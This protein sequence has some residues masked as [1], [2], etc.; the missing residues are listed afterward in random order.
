M[1]VQM[2]DS[3][4]MA[5]LEGTVI[6]YYTSGSGTPAEPEPLADGLDLAAPFPNPAATRATVRYTTDAAGPVRVRLLDVLGRQLAVLAD[7]D[8]PPGTHRAELDAGR[9]AAG[10]YAV[11]LEAGGQRRVRMLTVAR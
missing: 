10:V 2:D 9:L 7:G 5:D 8:R 6:R 4:S 3:I 11:V 1:L